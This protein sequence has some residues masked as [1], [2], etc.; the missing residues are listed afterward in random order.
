MWLLQNRDYPNEDNVSNG[1]NE[2]LIE[3]L[4][5]MTWLVLAP[6]LKT[7]SIIA[8]AKMGEI[9]SEVLVKLQV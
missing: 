5:D 4:K 7:L 3:E 6:N 8:C 1:D 9:L 2:K